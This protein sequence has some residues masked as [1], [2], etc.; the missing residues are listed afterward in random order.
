MDKS[1][2]VMVN[3]SLD[4]GSYRNKHQGSSDGLYTFNI[5][6]F[7]NAKTTPSGGGDKLAA[8][9]VQRV[10]GICRSILENPIYQKLGF[11]GNFVMRTM[12]MGIE[13]LYMKGDGDSLNHRVCRL[14]LEV[15]ANEA[16]TL[17]EG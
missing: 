17:P 15:R 5:D 11:A 4:N 10:I 16:I 1:E 9:K 8:L 13:M 6:A 3:I 12:V 7:A 14:T 2:S